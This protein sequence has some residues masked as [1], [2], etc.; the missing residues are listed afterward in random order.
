VVRKERKPGVVARK[1]SSETS[2]VKGM[3]KRVLIRLSMLKR[4]R[5]STGEKGTQAVVCARRRRNTETLDRC[6]A[7]VGRRSGVQQTAE[8]QGGIAE[9]RVAKGKVGA[10][11]VDNEHNRL[12]E[13]LRRLRGV[14]RGVIRAR[15]R[16]QGLTAC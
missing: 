16:R 2:R 4:R 15:A 10:K 13:G 7:R 6:L 11:G 3:Q 8:L 1:Y 5:H 14:V 9:R 12:R